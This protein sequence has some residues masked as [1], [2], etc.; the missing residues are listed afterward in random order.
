MTEEQNTIHSFEI[1]ESNAGKRIDAALPG[2]ISDVSRNHIQK[3]IEEG[4]VKVNGKVQSSK[5][6]KVGQGDFISVTLPKP[7]KLKVEAQDIDL[8][9]VYEDKDLL[10]V[11]KPKGMVVHPAAGNTEGT[12]VNALL[13]HCTNLSGI[14][15]VIRPGI[16]HRIDKDTSG[17]LMIAKND[18]A[19]R[20]LT[21]QLS[22]HTITRAYRAIVY[23]NFSEDTGRIDAPIGRDPKN[24][25]RMAVTT[26]NGKHAVTHYT[27]L[28]RFG[29]FTYIEAKLETGRTHQIRVHMAY[30]KHPLL[31]D[32]VYGPKKG[33][34]G[35]KSQM[36]H[37]K[38]LG[39]IH[40]VSGDY[41]EFESDLPEEFEAVLEKLRKRK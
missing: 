33:I 16:V 2:L 24:R 36:L 9:I 5:K 13:Y 37:A 11:N 8:K 7:Q 35:V 10:V 40:P 21:K 17:L 19:H 12:L 31:G 25:L 41:M 15:G 20:S 30:K 26:Q 1:D 23:H 29:D 14:N 38:V 32:E 28:E 6:Y 39:F 4:Q 34:F 22:E 3:L 18:T 27:V